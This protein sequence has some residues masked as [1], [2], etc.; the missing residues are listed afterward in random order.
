MTEPI[1]LCESLIV[2][3]KI[4]ALEV[5]ALQGLDL[6]VQRGEMIGIV[7]ASGSG[8]STLMNVLGGL[9][10]PSAGRAIVNGQDLLKLSDAALDA[11]RRKQ[12]GFVWQMGARNLIPYLNAQENVELPMTLAGVRE[13]RQ[14]AVELLGMVGLAE[15]R[16]HHLS[17]L[18]GGEQLRVAIAVSLA[19]NP[20]ILLADEPTGE[21]DTAT[22]KAVY[23]VFRTLNRE[24]GLTILIVS[25]D[26]SIARQVDRVMA[27]RD[28][29]A[30]SETVR[31]TGTAPTGEALHP[32]EHFE[33]LTVMDA[34]GRLQIPKAY[35]D[36]L[37]MGRRVRLELKEDSVMVHPILEQEMKS[38]AESPLTAEAEAGGW[39][40]RLR[41]SV[42][43]WV[44]K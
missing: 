43:R 42:K 24:L 5:Q 17:Q 34:A 27:I 10:R 1:I 9:A 19:N 44:S 23:D 32:D 15:R 11:Y 13:P 8:K 20:A 37:A 36:K 16:G 12:I 14:R 28:G 31:K 39:R 6:S 2:I 40:D 21:L 35:R 18:S 30:A 25:H 38:V 26:P 7:G 33:E 4:A 29:K 3:Y 22:A 41:R